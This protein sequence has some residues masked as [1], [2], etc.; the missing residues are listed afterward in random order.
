ML[1]TGWTVVDL[2]EDAPFDL[3]DLDAPFVLGEDAGL[4]RR[5]MD[6]PFDPGDFGA[7][8]SSPAFDDPESAD[9][10]I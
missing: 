3:R 10:D 9:L 8:V 4:E 1:L 7:L 5:D 2:A 6:E